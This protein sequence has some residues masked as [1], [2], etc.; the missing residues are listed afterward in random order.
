MGR[1]KAHQRDSIDFK[2]DLGALNGPENIVLFRIIAGRLFP[3]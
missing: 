1:K 2:F 3:P